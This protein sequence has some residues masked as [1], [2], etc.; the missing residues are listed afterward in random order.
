MSWELPPGLRTVHGLVASD[1]PWPRAD[2]TRRMDGAG[3]WLDL[4]AATQGGQ[5]ESAS[6]VSQVRASGNHSGDV[7]VFESSWSGTEERMSDGALA[8]ALVGT[9]TT[10]VV[11]FRTVW[12]Y[13]VVLA[14]IALLLSIIRGFALGPALGAFF[15]RMRIMGTRKALQATLAQI[16]RNIGSNAVAALQLAKR[17]L[18]R[19]LIVPGMQT[20]LVAA[21]TL[22]LN[23]F[24]DNSRAREE[25]EL[26]LKQTP[27]GRAALAYAEE[28]GITTLYQ[29]GQNQYGSGYNRNLNVIQ[30]G[31]AD[32]S[33]PEAMAGEFV[34][35]VE[36]AK[37]RW[38][39]SPLG[40]DTGEY[41][42]ARGR[43]EEA[44]NRAAYRFGAQLG[45][46]EDARATYGA[47]DFTGY[48]ADGGDIVYEHRQGLERAILNGPFKLFNDGPLDYTR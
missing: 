24:D 3:S 12:K 47:N 38:A 41:A 15:S 44:A 28:H 7:S 11:V 4:A 18:A 32:W 46:E 42:E 37:S 13:V 21:E 23:P 26:V 43:E 2:E 17:M 33:T 5:A 35:Q 25:A 27:E 34:R 1:A 19:G 29:N 9:G 45:Y 31:G 39:P 6:A 36:I 30:I 16:E 10:A 40:M 14:L 22:S 20:V 48:G 8:N